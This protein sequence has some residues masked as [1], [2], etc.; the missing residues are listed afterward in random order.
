MDVRWDALWRLLQD[1]LSSEPRGGGGGGGGGGPVAWNSGAG[2]SGAGS[3]GAG[4]GG[5]TGA[6]ADGAHLAIREDPVKGFYVH[7]LK[8]GLST[9]AVLYC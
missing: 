7:G 1:L 2:A 9:R 4:G 6:A 3:G 5:V 8:A